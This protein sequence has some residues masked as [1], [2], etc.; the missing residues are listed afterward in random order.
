MLALA[1]FRLP[2][3]ESRPRFV[4]SASRLLRG[5]ESGFCEHTGDFG[6]QP[7]ARIRPAPFASFRGRTYAAAVSPESSRIMAELGI[8]ILIIPQKPW[9][10]VVT[11]LDAYRTVF[12]EVNGVEAPPPVGVAWVFCDRD[13]ARAEELGHRYIGGYYH[14]AVRHSEIAAGHFAA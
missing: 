1:G 14:S 2:V 3:D 8:G 7:R 10:D 12:R 4:E 11:E 6:S 5:L 9:E 13:P